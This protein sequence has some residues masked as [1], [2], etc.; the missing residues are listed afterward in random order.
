MKMNLTNAV[1]MIVGLLVLGGITLFMVAGM[2]QR[3][4]WVPLD[5]DAKPAA[6][7]SPDHWKAL[8]SRKLFFAHMSVGRDI[9][10]GVEDLQRES[11]DAKLAIR[12]SSDPAAMTKPVL[13]HALLGHNGDPVAKIESFRQLMAQLK[14]S[15]PDVA[16]MKFCYVD[17]R[18]DTDVPRLFAAYAAAMDKL[19]A[20]LPSTRFAHLTVPLCSPPTGGKQLLKAPI[21]WLL[22]RPD[23]AADNLKREAFNQLLRERYAAKGEL[24]DIAEA[25]C[26]GPRGRC[27]IK[28]S[29]QFVSCLA[30]STPPTAAT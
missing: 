23:T 11:F 29:G 25:E 28:R 22:G 13:A 5:P 24:I 10:G 9:L 6:R 26:S 18:H 12:E 14:S 7:L 19:Q 15:P 16:C 1:L 17:I 27:V 21:K 20:E 2:S 4:R 8:A 3:V 30:R